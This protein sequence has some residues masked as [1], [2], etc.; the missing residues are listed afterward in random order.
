MS[1]DSEGRLRVEGTKER[2][3]HHLA[4]KIEEEDR[5]RKT[6]KEEPQIEGGM[7]DD[8]DGATAAASGENPPTSVEEPPTKKLKP[9]DEE[10]ET[11]Q[12]EEPGEPSEMMSA[13]EEMLVN[14]SQE[15]ASVGDTDAGSP[16]QAR[17]IDISEV[18]SPPRV[19]KVAEEYGLKPGDALD[20]ITGWN[21]DLKEHMGKGKR[22][23]EEE[24]A[25]AD[26]RIA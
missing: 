14:S 1:E 13:L 3:S 2:M 15:M 20:L 7:P 6:S 10:M 18:F 4:R 12:V 23:D 19:T 17:S 9:D 26:H 16:K 21:F 11:E 24:E 25:K 5:K 22:V 8:S